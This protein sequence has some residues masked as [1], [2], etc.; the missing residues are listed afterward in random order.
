D[1]A[2]RDLARR[3]QPGV[4]EAGD[5]VP[6]RGL[7]AGDLREQAGHAQRLVVVGLDRGRS[8]GRADRDQAGARTGRG[9]GAGLDH[10]SHRLGGVRVDDLDDHALDADYASADTADAAAAASAAAA[11]AAALP[12]A[13]PATFARSA[14][15]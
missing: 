3:V 10:P 8:H 6:V 11:A 12:S 14:R 4:A 15:T 2:G 7:A 1:R 9:P 5:D 13:V